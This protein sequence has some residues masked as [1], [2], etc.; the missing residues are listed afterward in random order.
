[1]EHTITFENRTGNINVGKIIMSMYNDGDTDGITDDTAVNIHVRVTAPTGVIYDTLTALSATSLIALDGTD[2]RTISI[3]MFGGH[4]V[5]GSYIFEIRVS[6]GSNSNT[7]TLEYEYCIEN[8]AALTFLGNCQGPSLRLSDSSSL[9]GYQLLARAM[10]LVH[11]TIEGSQLDNTVTSG[12]FLSVVP[13]HNN[14]SYT[15]LLSLEVQKTATVTGTHDQDGTADADFIANFTWTTTKLFQFICNTSLSAISK[16]Y[17]DKLALIEAKACAVGGYQALSKEMR[18][19]MTTLQNLYT[20][21]QMAKECGDY[22]KMTTHFNSL[23]QVLNCDCCGSD[24]ISETTPLEGTTTITQDIP[25]ADVP[26]DMLMDGWAK[27]AGV[28]V[29]S[30]LKWKVVNGVFYMYGRIQKAGVAI[31]ILPKAFLSTAFLT[32]IGVNVTSLFRSPVHQEPTAGS[33]IGNVGWVFVNGTSFFI[34]VNP[35]FDTAFPVAINA[36]IPL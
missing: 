21:Y 27:A 30:F 1:M 20:M 28:G 15:G 5:S 2:T 4:Y 7:L 23:K 3:P 10:T 19:L 29:D 13:T 8:K 25:W 14:V 35:D 12:L 9:A 26:D 24:G 33:V 34:T 36:A 18:D 11:P 6:E 31:N 16:C 17:E 22:D 32:S